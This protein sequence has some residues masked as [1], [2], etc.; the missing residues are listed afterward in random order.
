[1]SSTSLK[2][3]EPAA[4]LGFSVYGN[5]TSR[6]SGVDSPYLAKPQISYESYRRPTCY[7]GYSRTDPEKNELLGACTKVVHLTRHVGTELHG[8]QLEHLTD[9]QKYELGL[10]IAERSVV[11]FRDQDISQQSLLL[12]EEWHRE[13]EGY[14]QVAQVPGVP[15]VT[16][17]GPNFQIQGRTVNFGQS[18]GAQY[19]ADHPL[20]VTRRNDVAPDYGH[21]TFGANGLT[22]DKFQFEWTPGTSALWDD[23][24]LRWMLQY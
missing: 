18:N 11:F 9:M 20:D 22:S 5:P 13:S 19:L 14:P 21:D 24:V 17:I 2:T 15:G 12:L 4:P 3:L 8:I 23:R 6:Q 7:N 10:L 1:M 16:V